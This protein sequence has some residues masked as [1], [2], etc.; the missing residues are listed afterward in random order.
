MNSASIHGRGMWALVESEQ[1][2]PLFDE[3]FEA[4]ASVTARGRVLKHDG[5][6][7]VTVVGDPDR[8]WV[9]KRYNTKNAWHALRR[10]F[11]TSRAVN[12]WRAASRLRK[13]G[14]DTP[15][16]VA[17]M[18]E[19][20]FGILRGRSWFI[21]E[22]IDGDTLAQAI[23]H[24]T[25]HPSPLVAQ[26]ADIVLRLRTAGIVHGDLKATNFLVHGDR[27]YLVDLDATR[28]PR[29]RRLEAG[30]RKDLARFLRNWSDRPDLLG[31]FQDRLAADGPAG[32]PPR[33]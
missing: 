25:G 32:P 12:C 18:E 14:I 31:D 13:A 17:A 15:R 6:T 26:A 24:D 9:V 5:T 21:S 7:T 11:R 33:L 29:G 19:R 2:C 3:L 1:R 28:N 23:G 22:Y 20:R 16:P 8:C 10:L 4:P 30:L 27:I